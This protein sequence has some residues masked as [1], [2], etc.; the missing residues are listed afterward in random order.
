MKKIIRAVLVGLTLTAFMVIA[1]G[2]NV[3][4]EEQVIVES[5]SAIFESDSIINNNDIFQTQAQAVCVNTL[6]ETFL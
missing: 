2:V 5:N 3:Q 4:A 1:F 6:A